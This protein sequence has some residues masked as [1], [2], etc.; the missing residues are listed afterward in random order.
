MN[1]SLTKTSVWR[2][3]PRGMLAIVFTLVVGAIGSTVLYFYQSNSLA[4]TL[5]DQFASGALI[6]ELTMEKGFKDYIRAGESFDAFYVTHD[7]ASPQA[8]SKFTGRAFQ[9][10]PAMRWTAWVPAPGIDENGAPIKPGRHTAAGTN[11]GELPIAF[12]KGLAA[13][14]HAGSLRG[15]EM[16]R[17]P[18]WREALMQARD[19]GEPQIALAD[20]S[21]SSA[22]QEHG[23]LMVWPIYRNGTSHANV[24]QR[25][26]N[27][28]GYVVGLV[29]GKTIIEKSLD[30]GIPVAGGITLE[31]KMGGAVGK[32]SDVWTHISRSKAK[33]AIPQSMV[34]RLGHHLDFQLGGKHWSIVSTAVQGFFKN[35][36]ISLPWK[37]ASLGSLLTLM[38]MGYFLFAMRANATRDKLEADRLEAA[39]QKAR[40]SDILNTSIID[41]L[42]SVAKTAKGDLTVQAP[43]REDVTGALSDAINS[44]ADST[45]RTLAR[46]AATSREVRNASVDGRDTVLQTSRGMNEIRG[47]IQ[48]TGKR[49]KQLG[50]R[51]Q[52][53][54]G[55]VKLIDDISE[56][57]SVLALNA[58][59]QAAI[60]G[61]AGRGFRVVADEV[62]RLAE[63]SKEATDQIGKLVSAIQTETNDTMATMDRA[64]SEVVKGGEMADKAAEKVTHL[65]ELGGALLESI[66]AFKLPETY[67]R[68]SQADIA[69]RSADDRRV[70]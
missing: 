35:R 43:V 63:R 5:Q 40:E 36:D 38:V 1:A 39:E 25:H 29:D 31:T 33:V 53:I 49:I 24:A 2:G 27:L 9:S 44:M 69:E 10:Y 11:P 50:E 46:V 66:Q 41:I 67:V 19:S 70:A 17:I 7:V 56:R 16:G 14:Q 45:A 57:T 60:A 51:S 3:L 26:R 12:A 37:T 15:L 47:T 32:K 23:V 34:D 21:V 22:G 28:R 30:F 62:Q 59:M 6:H 54:T 42:R 13:N 68:Q 48:E 64:I 61:E 52:E 4:T 55:I 65:D 18:Q 20:P 58:N 8:F